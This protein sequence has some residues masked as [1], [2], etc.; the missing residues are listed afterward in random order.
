MLFIKVFIL[1]LFDQGY[2]FREKNEIGNFCM[3][4][5]EYLKYGGRDFLLFR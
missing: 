1:I 4:Y 5:Q 2:P 3:F